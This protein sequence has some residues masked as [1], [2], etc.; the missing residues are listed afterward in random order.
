MYDYSDFVKLP[1]T[2][3]AGIVFF[4]NYFRLAHYAYEALMASLGFSLRSVLEGGEFLLL[5]VHAEADY[6]ASLRT[7]DRYTITVEIER[8]G[9]RSFT[10]AYKVIEASDR[11]VAELKT[12][13]VATN[14]DGSESQALPPELKAR[15]GELMA[16]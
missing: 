12:V 1:D 5:I 13:H 8:L 2:D 11:I 9:S 16:G 14:G 7:G 10:L 6:R 3:G 4:G 15:L